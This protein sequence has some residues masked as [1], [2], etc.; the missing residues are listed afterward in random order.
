MQSLQAGAG[1]LMKKFYNYAQKRAASPP[2]KIPPFE[3]KKRTATYNQLEN[4][5]TSNHAEAP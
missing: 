3:Q 1:N 2:E 4:I 5:P